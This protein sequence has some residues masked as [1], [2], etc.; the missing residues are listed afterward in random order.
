M[1]HTYR[2]VTT[3]C[4]AYQFCLHCVYN[5]SAHELRSS[6][7][8]AD[9]LSICHNF[10]ALTNSMEA[11]ICVA[12]RQLEPEGSLLNSQGLSTCPYPDADQFS[13]HQTTLSLRDLS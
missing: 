13:P 7:S 9:T 10:L 5:A 11:T 6:A 2:A 1:I 3:K 8:E 12:I 4:K